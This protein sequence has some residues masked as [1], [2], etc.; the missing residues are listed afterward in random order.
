MIDTV[1]RN[2]MSNALKFTSTGDEVKVA[3]NEGD[4]HFSE[5]Y[6][7]DTGVGIS[8]DDL[9]KLFKVDVHHSTAGTSQEAGTGLGLFLCQEMVT[10]NGIQLLMPIMQKVNKLFLCQEMV[11]YNGGRIWI[12]SKLGQGTEVKFTVPIT[13]SD[14][15]RL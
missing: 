11:T 8:Q 5:V 12:E 14:F 3:V 1:I 4:P 7:A 15:I 6:V 2:L 10:Y 9:E 13:E